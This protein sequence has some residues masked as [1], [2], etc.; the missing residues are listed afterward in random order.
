MWHFYRA[1]DT[2]GETLVFDD[3]SSL[4]LAVGDQDRAARLWGAAR[5]LTSSTGAGL[6][7]FVDEAIEYDARPN[8]RKTMPPE[9]LEAL[10]REGAAMALDEIVAYAL[11][12]TVDEL[13]AQTD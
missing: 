1:S 6:A 3:L 9:R 2:A 13:R 11:G 4:E 8:I 5:S 7:A 12:I 10:G